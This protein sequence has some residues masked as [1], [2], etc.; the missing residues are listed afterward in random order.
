MSYSTQSYFPDGDG[1]QV[2]TALK[3]YIN[4]LRMRQKNNTKESNVE[5][6]Q[7]RKYNRDNTKTTKKRRQENKK[8]KQK[9]RRVKMGVV[10]CLHNLKPRLIIIVIKISSNCMEAET[11]KNK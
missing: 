5:N 3:L 6:K 11:D 7:N 10:T 9:K 8:Q 1:V 4:I 2:I